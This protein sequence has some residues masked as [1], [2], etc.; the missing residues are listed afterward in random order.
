M[1]SLLTVINH[2]GPQAHC[3][4]ACY[5]A[6]S[7]QCDC[8]CGGE[9][10]G[11]GFAAADLHTAINAQRLAQTFARTRPELQ[12]SHYIRNG[13]SYPIHQLTMF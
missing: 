12:L 1:S 7:P 8:V 11:R 6:T 4:S 5:N 3:G 10:H 9:N 13:K 2:R